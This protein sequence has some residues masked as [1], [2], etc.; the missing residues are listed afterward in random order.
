I[1]VSTARAMG[2]EVL[3]C[4]G[5]N[6]VAVAEHTMALILALARHI[7]KADGSMKAGKW[8]KKKLKG[9]GLSGRTLGIIGFGRIGREVSHRAQCMGMRVLVNQPRLTPELALEAKVLVRDLPDLLRESDIVSLH[10]PM[11]PENVGLIGRKELGL[12]QPTAYLINTA[13]GGIVDEEAL[14]EA[15]ESGEIAGAG[16][17]VYEEE[18][19]ID[20]P[21]AKHP[22]VVAT[23]HIA[24][25]TDEAQINAAV[26][27]AQ[28]VTNYLA[29]EGS[30]A[31][32]LSLQVVPIDQV[33]PHEATDPK[34]VARLA[35]AVEK[36]GLLVNPPVVAEH[37][38]RYVVLDGATRT[39]ACKQLGLPHLVVQLTDPN[40]KDVSLHTW[41]HV[42]SGTSP[43]EL[44]EELKL[45]PGLKLTEI[46]ATDV[47]DALRE[48]EAL[49]SIALS[50]GRF[51]HVEVTSNEYNW[52][53]VLNQMVERYTLW[54]KVSRTLTNDL[55]QLKSTYTDM[56]ALV[57]FP[58]FQPED[59]L[60][61]AVQ[62]RTLP[63]GITRFIIP[64]RVLRLNVPLDILASDDTLAAKRRWLDQFIHD[65]LNRQRVRYYQEPVILLED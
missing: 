57:V 10:V 52:L 22:K 63:Q 23:P 65:K 14:L 40:S 39:A 17:D 50:D 61:A 9:M 47:H 59:A 60:E 51:F 55:D 32:T 56:V 11:R 38:E 3:N 21:L 30:V 7:S 35:A 5:A 19:A 20:H 53:D 62:G 15:L 12:M 48:R 54:G 27:I 44:L 43:D 31:A 2:V 34:R 33:I 6:S 64:G 4:P 29:V 1:D 37:Q 18:P 58:Q 8:E 41:Y 49:A 25:S 28:Q 42:V 16:I 24:A 26:S 13:R 46:P 45:I 36:D